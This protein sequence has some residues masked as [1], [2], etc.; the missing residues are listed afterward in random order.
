MSF[1]SS[2]QL[3]LCEWYCYSLIPFSATSRRFSIFGAQS[4]GWQTAEKKKQS[5]I[6]VANGS[7]QTGD[8]VTQWFLSGHTGRLHSCEFETHPPL[9]SQPLE[10][11]WTAPDDRDSLVKSPRPTSALK[12][13][14]YDQNAF[15]GR[16][17]AITLPLTSWLFA[18][19]GMAACWLWPIS[20]V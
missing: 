10:H 13:Q 14:G 11:G 1:L 7:L 18:G 4:L 3:H 16:R 17:Q 12:E 19:P 8:S 2:S 5:G 9:C 6:V 15:E 20:W